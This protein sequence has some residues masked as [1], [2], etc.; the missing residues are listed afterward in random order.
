MTASAGFATEDGYDVL[1]FVDS[2]GAELAFSDTT[3][4]AGVSITAATCDG[5]TWTGLSEVDCHDGAGT[6]A[7]ALPNVPGTTT[8]AACEGA[9]LAGGAFTTSAAYVPGGHVLWSSDTWATTPADE[10]GAGPGRTV[11][12][13]SHC[14]CV[15]LIRV[16]PFHSFI[17]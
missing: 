9:A 16:T 1:T 10:V 13:Y 17:H 14:R 6:C 5:V 4:P 11:A 2:A 12:S 15:P 8:R 3:G 7:G